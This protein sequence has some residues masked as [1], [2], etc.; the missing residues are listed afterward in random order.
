[1]FTPALL[2]VVAAGELDG[3]ETEGVVVWLVAGGAVPLVAGAVAAPVPVP[4]ADPE[5][6]L[7][8]AKQYER[9]KVA[10]KKKNYFRDLPHSVC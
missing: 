1:V 10:K 5:A 3:C 8:A 7:P 4:V 6:P 2:E 9:Q